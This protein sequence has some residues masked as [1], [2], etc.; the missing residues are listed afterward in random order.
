MKLNDIKTQSVILIVVVS[1]LGF[2]LTFLVY[3]QTDE[4]LK[5]DLLLKAQ[6]ITE[7][8]EIEH[9]KQFVPNDSI[10]E[11]S[12]YET[13]VFELARIMGVTP[14]FANIYIFHKDYDDNIVFLVDLIH[15]LSDEAINQEYTKTLATKISFVQDS[16]I[17]E[18]HSAGAIYHDATEALINLFDNQIPFVEGPFGDEY[19]IWVSALVPLLDPNTGQTVAVFG[20]DCDAT[21]WKKSFITMLALPIIMILLLYFLVFLSLRILKSRQKVI[22][23]S[24]RINKQRDVL[25]N[26]TMSDKV[27]VLGFDKT[28]DHL[29]KLLTET[30][31]LDETSLWLLSEDKKTFLGKTKFTSGNTYVVQNSLYI[32]DFPDFFKFIGDKKL[33]SISNVDKH[34]ILNKF[35]KTIFETILPK[36][37]IIANIWYNMEIIGILA[38]KSFES[39]R[40]WH[41]DEESFIETISAIISQVI[42]KNEKDKAE[43]ELLESKQRIENTLESI[44]DGFIYFN[45]DLELKFINHHTMNIL[46]FDINW[47]QYNQIWGLLPKTISN[48]IKNLITIASEDNTDVTKIEHVESLNKWIEF[49]VYPTKEDVSIFVSDITKRKMSEKAILENQR[50]SAIGEMANAFSHDFNNYLQVILANIEVLYQKLK[51]LNEV[52]EYLQTLQVTTND[53]ATRVQLL[54]RFAGTKN[55]VSD[56]ERVNL[57]SVVVEAIMQS[58]PIWKTEPEKK[59]VSI[60]MCESLSDIIYVNGN[61]NELRS[62]LYNLI[63]NSTEAMPTGG[64]ISIETFAKEDTVYLQ[65]TDN[66]EGMTEEVAKRVFEPFFTTRGFDAGKGLGLCGVYNII[67]EHG[68]KINILSTKVAEGTTFEITLPRL[69]IAENIGEKSD[70]KKDGKPTILWVDDDAM[71]R[72]IGY[73]MLTIID[74]DVT[75]ANGGAEALDILTKKD[76]DILL[77]DIGMPGMSG[78]QLMDKVNELYPNKFKRVLISGWGDQVTDEQKHEHHIDYVLAKPVKMNQMKKLL[79]ELWGEG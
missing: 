57:N 4:Y 20:V 27:V 34:P 15:T 22:E 36:S 17:I 49:R 30:L 31:N 41:S 2:I 51:S 59:G 43:R 25:S 58:T 24:I 5:N 39:S 69:K 77:S 26:F 42:V 78:W 37:V 68:G 16:Y 67:N 9:I 79:E 46:G 44:T 60:K 47:T 63:K 56:Y 73:D 74:Y 23:R 35:Y 50:L 10:Y 29:V 11:Q 76:F 65:I 12:G 33:I 6:I 28:L 48:L 8:L 1:V 7:S 18:T 64:V 66:G 62:V 19:G 70:L 61:E 21:G 13:T 55:K 40:V 38:I 3:Q 71:I 52:R 45:K 72:Q 54:Q 14:K 75:M 32:P 53:A